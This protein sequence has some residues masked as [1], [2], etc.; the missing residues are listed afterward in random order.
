MPPISEH[1][2][3][4]LATMLEL[5][6]IS[7]SALVAIR[8]CWSN[9]SSYQSKRKLYALVLVLLVMSWTLTPCAVLAKTYSKFQ[10]PPPAMPKS[11]RRGA[12]SVKIVTPKL[13]L[14]SEPT[15]AELS[16]ARTLSVPLVPMH[17]AAVAG[18]N[19]AL[20]KA[21]SVHSKQTDK[22]DVAVLEDFVRQFPSSRWA[23]SVQL[24]IAQYLFESGYFADAIDRWQSIWTATKTE[25]QAAQK[26]IADEAVANLMLFESRLGRTKELDELVKETEHRAFFGSIEKK[27]A[28]ARI[29]LVMQQKSPRFSYKCGPYAVSTLLSLNEKS[30][31]THKLIK[32][33]ES[34]T[35]GTN[36]EQVKELAD[37][38]GLRYQMAKRSPGAPVIVPAVTHWKVG[39]YGAL[40][41][42]SNGKYHISDPTFDEKGSFWVTAKVLDTET[43]GYCLVPAGNLPS[44]WTAV[45]K[46]EGSKVWGKGQTYGATQG[47]T[48]WDPYN[49]PNPNS[50]PIGMAKPRMAGLQAT[51]S[52]NDTPLT[53]QCPVGPSVDSSV[54]FNYQEGNQPTLWAFSNLG[55]CWSTNWV[56]YLSVD[57]SKNV[58]VNVRGGGY[59]IYN[60]AI[61]DNVKNP[62][63]PSLLSQATIT[64]PSAGVYQRQTPDGTIEVYN[65]PDGYGHI[66]MTQ[67]IDPQGNSVYLQ[68]N[69]NMRLESVTDAIG[70]AT[71]FSY[72]S[73]T[74]VS[75]SASPNYYRITQ[76]TDPFGRSATFTYDA[77]TTSFL[78]AITDTMGISSQFLYDTGATT[79]SIV[80]ETTPYGTTRFVTA[81]YSDGAGN[82]CTQLKFNF[83]DGSAAATVCVWGFEVNATSVYFDRE[84][85]QLVPTGYQVSY[86]GWKAQ[87]WNKQWMTND[88]YI[89]QPVPTSFSP[90][91]LLG[92]ISYT[93]NGSGT[94]PDGDHPTPGPCGKP[95]VVK[96]STT[97]GAVQTYSYSYN[98]LGHVTQTIDPV[99]RTFTYKYAANNID[100]LE[101][102]QTQGSNNDLLGKWIFNNNMHV[103]NKYID[104]SG[105]TTVYTYNNYGQLLTTTDALG[106]VSTRN[107]SVD[108]FLTSV[109]GP[110]PGNADTTTFQYDG[111]N[112][113]YSV[114]DSEGYTR[115]FQ[116]DNSAYAANDRGDRLTLTTY[117]D[118]TTEQTIYCNLDAILRKDRIG[119]WTEDSFDSMDQLSFD[120]DPLGRK[121]SYTW[122]SCGSLGSITDPNG[123]TTSF[124]H[125]IRGQVTTKTYPDGTALNYG[126]DNFLGR[127]TSRTDALGQITSYSYN[128]DN[129]L[130]SIVYS[131]T[132]NPTSSV[133][134]TWD[135]NYNRLANIANG[136]GTYT[137]TYNPFITDPFGTPT[138][139][140]GMLSGVSNNVI[141]N[142]GISYSYDAIGRTTNRQINGSAN[143]VT[144]NYDPMSRVVS[145]VNALG[146]FGYKYVDDL[147]GSSKG[148]TRLASISYPNGQNTNF[149]WYPTNLDERLQSI[150]NLTPSGSVM[151]QFSYGYDS[152]GEITNWGQQGAGQ[153]PI[154]YNLGYDLAGQLISAQS[155]FGRATSYNRNQY[156]YAY[157]AG[158][159]RTSV[160]QTKGQTALIGGSVT[161]GDVLTITIQDSGLGGGQES[162]SYTVQ[163][164]DSLSAIAKGL[165]TALSADSNLQGLGVNASAN[166]NIVKLRSTSPNVTTYTQS[167]SS[168]ATETISFG[169]STNAIQNVVVSLLGSGYT[170]T[171]G[172]VLKV[173]AYDGALSGGHEVVS[174]TVPS[175]GTS[176]G[177]IAAGLATAINSDSALSS[178]GITAS[179]AS[180]GLLS[181]ASSSANLTTY[182][183]SASP[184]SAAGSETLTF[185]ANS[186][187]NTTIA[188]G[189]TVTSG[190]MV[191]LTATT[192]GLSGGRESVVLRVPS[193]ATTTSIA[194]ALASSINADSNF[195]TYGMSA[196]ASGAIVTVSS[197]PTYSKSTSSGA[198]ETITLGTNTNGRISA[199]IGGTVTAGDALT[200][201][202][203][204]AGLSSPQNSSYTV[205][206]G[207]T[208]A[209][210]ALGLSNKI[211]SLASLQT[212]GVSATSNNA[213]VNIA[214]RPTNYPIYSGLI[215]SGANEVLSQTMNNNGIEQAL[216]GGTKTTGDTIGLRVVDAGLPAGVETV[217]YTVLSTDTLPTIASG[218]VNAVNSDS[219]LQ[220]VGVSATASSTSLSLKSNSVNPTSYSQVTNTGATETLV[221]GLNSNGTEAVAI[222]GTKTTGDSV[223]M[224]VCDSGLSS[225]KETV[226]YTVQSSDNLT[227][228]AS[229]LVAAINA[230]TNLS[231]I[232]ISATANSTVVFITSTSLNL[233]TYSSSLNSGATETL[234]QSAS[235][236]VT[237][238]ACNQLNQ[239]VQINPA[240]AVGFKGS[241]NKAVK[242]MA[243]PCMNILSTPP[244]TYTPY[245]NAPSWMN[246]VFTTY[247]NPTNTV[248]TL[249]AGQ[250]YG[251]YTLTIQS[252]ALAGG[253]T[254]Y[255]VNSPSS[256][257]VVLPAFAADITADTQ[258]QALGITA[259]ATAAALTITDR[260]TYSISS[261]GTSEVLKL[262]P[263]YE[264]NASIAIGGTPTVGDTITL[265]TSF[266]PFSGGI[267]NT[268]YT[269]VSGDTMAT[270]AS[271]FTAVVNADTTLEGIGVSATNNSVQQT[272]SNTFYGGNNIGAGQNDVVVSGVDG[273][274][275]TTANN[276]LLTNSQA[277]IQY[278]GS[279]SAGATETLSFNTSGGT[280]TLSLGGT[281][282]A[283]DLLTINVADPLLPSGPVQASYTVQSG[284]TLSS[285]ATNLASALNNL[286]LGTI[287]S[288]ASSTVTLQTSASP[289]LYYDRNGNLINDGTRTYQWDTENRLV[290]INYPGSG[291][292][293]QLAYDPYGKNVKI[294]ETAGGSVASTKQFVYSQSTMA[295]A[296]DSSGNNLNRY[297]SLGEYRGANK[298]FYFT[299]HLGSVWNVADSSGSIVGNLSYSPYGQQM[300]L[301]GTVI[302]D[303]GFTGCYHHLASGLILTL[304][305]PY[306]PASGRFDAR[307]AIEEEGGVNMYCYVLNQPVN[308]TDRDGFDAF[309]G[310]GFT[311]CKT[312]RCCQANSTRCRR[313]AV[314]AC[315]FKCDATCNI[316]VGA[317][318]NFDPTCWESCERT[319][320]KEPKPTPCPNPNPSPNPNPNPNPNPG[321]S[322]TPNPGTGPLID[323]FTLLWLL[324]ELSRLYPPRNFVPLP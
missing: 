268:S 307:D 256:I 229:G 279:T 322:P 215:T 148:S 131:Y 224:S 272:A 277:Q 72:A 308:R 127:L 292:Y 241:T 10:P 301:N 223:T 165:A 139:G 116:Y 22:Y 105:Q 96:Q 32:E 128:L 57:A 46:E 258:M 135:P 214:F 146:T 129:T 66:L 212:A 285:I 152:A 269:V 41:R 40:T 89:L 290:Q 317:G 87:A 107:Y 313:V 50:C 306:N 5:E 63:L 162:V 181:I 42:Q 243:L 194:S 273:G 230:D 119:R 92:T 318:K 78:L 118:G 310:A 168:G 236:G 30:P 302:P 134:F 163:P 38:V 189:G 43:D 4:A 47:L 204:G 35:Q 202:T 70:E 7:K 55:N 178:L 179:S 319:Q 170:S 291:N 296:R 199:T 233:T 62:Y 227:S 100:L 13:S 94:A 216:V 102:R 298:Y 253:Q 140:G 278:T 79:S 6:C 289:T 201:T 270:I 11:V 138:T 106:N 121:R 166:G 122:C 109:D 82:T 73:N 274:G 161:A 1:I 203:S 17:V 220:S 69:S 316:Y 281:I 254:V 267:K 9:R 86:G 71:T 125:N 262:S 297:Y 250:A 263:S 182:S 195:A 52:I 265:K 33:A 321:N 114:T 174:Y 126:Y 160:Q 177:T 282:T 158:A 323:P 238:A 164:G 77:A 231:N 97:T 123:R 192:K 112:R 12:K 221:I 191:S 260:P 8:S 235:V 275:N 115:Y 311:N 209:S 312:S 104:G 136:W 14:G 67:V 108:G 264:G 176:V 150:T 173:T 149:S 284:D 169:I 315:C 37:K 68:Y 80:A 197:S 259:T 222:G 207:D 240:G 20:S 280:T 295:E 113:L 151:S 196:S 65:Q 205:Q 171:A 54:T 51:L 132:V 88:A 2:T 24:N 237:Q 59:E 157:D 239:I 304:S 91:G 90:P 99:G 271:K 200:I 211:D 76:I 257:G 103:P 34:T 193:G 208:L 187:G 156:Y 111:F 16:A 44:G 188:I 142:S 27:V 75:P 234:S 324:D 18:E 23:P 210:I 36:L 261:S 305:R 180:T 141:P 110:L 159:N 144:W 84:C 228:I 247:S 98:P 186:V 276:Y 242:S 143:S 218:L 3:K 48:P 25:K 28:S 251:A 124:Q 226:T 206:A 93:Y 147:S 31:K 299:D 81:R 255:T 252:P 246:N 21:L 101:K 219:N 300:V 95:N 137:Y 217:S 293:S 286:T 45:S 133:N 249:T 183:A 213:V 53:Y 56:S 245:S 198:T 225:G 185:S 130:S 64:V 154:N 58:T 155:G 172:D 294:V 303:M 29:G 167:T 85:L 145:E 320:P 120:I 288:S 49:D 314:D 190:D 309:G 175:N 283:N 153:S 60:Y 74:F 244:P 39:H 83:P 287:A 117:P 61:P 26:T 232:G 19:A 184:T 266:S 15:D 248:I